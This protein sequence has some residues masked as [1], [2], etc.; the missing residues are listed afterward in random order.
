MKYVLLL[1]GN[2][3]TR[4]T[5]KPDALKQMQGAYM[6]YTAALQQSG[7][8]VS[9][10][11][12]QPTTAATTVRGANGKAQVIDGPFAETKEQ[13]A[14]FYMIDVPDLDGAMQWAR[15]CPATDGGTVE[16]RPLMSFPA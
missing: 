11:P 12:L 15:R 3:K 9:G 6:A 16:I 4:T 7:V 1:Y 14:G 10:A 13:L 2:E 8:Y 5:M